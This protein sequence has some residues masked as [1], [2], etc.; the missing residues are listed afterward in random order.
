[1]LQYKIILMILKEAK[2]KQP[3][4]I[5]GIEENTVIIAIYYLLRIPSSLYIWT[6]LILMTL[7]QMLD[8]NTAINNTDPITEHASW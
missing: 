4:E 3:E 2:E 7:R 1:M 5:V 6:P 8:L